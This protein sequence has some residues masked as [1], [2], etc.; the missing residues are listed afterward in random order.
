[1]D[2]L[3]RSVVKSNKTKKSVKIYWI[4]F[5]LVLALFA[6]VSIIATNSSNTIIMADVNSDV[7]G[8]IEAVGKSLEGITK[9]INTLMAD[10]YAAIMVIGTVLAITMISICLIIRMLSKNPRA[11]DEATAWI[12]RIAISWLLLM[13]L[14]VFL[15]YGLQIVHNSGAKTEDIWK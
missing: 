4:L 7:Q 9:A 14:S 5:T 10:V 15:E 8:D 11:A 13:L 3:N 12:K 6:T 1:M 2:A